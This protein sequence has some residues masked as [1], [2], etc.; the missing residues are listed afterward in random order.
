MQIHEQK[1]GAV[2]VLRPVGP[3]VQADADAFKAKAL[4]VRRASLGRF[5]IDASA[6]PYVDSRGLEALAE[7]HDELSRSGQSLKVCGV[8]PTVREVLELTEVGALV[9][10]YEDA[11]AAVR[12]FL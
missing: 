1:H 3:L 6:V 8:Q 10:P 9:E 5:V 11:G 2:T 12:S 4:E 7:M